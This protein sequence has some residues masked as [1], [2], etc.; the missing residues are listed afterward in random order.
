MS[1][2]TEINENLKSK[3]LEAYIF[4]SKEPVNIS[5]LQ[6]IENDN[7]KLNKLINV[8]QSKYID[9]GI[10]LVKIDNCFAFR[11]SDEVSKLLN[12]EQEISK[13]LSRPASETLAIIAYHQPITRSQ[14]ENIRGVSLGKGILDQL[15]D[16]GSSG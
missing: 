9:F 8:L 15:F 16:I 3:I 7:I 14:I 12:I 6:F 5:K 11:T 13:P 2:K 4:A 10:N 1:K